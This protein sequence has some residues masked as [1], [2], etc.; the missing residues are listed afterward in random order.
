MESAHLRILCCNIRVDNAGDRQQ[1]DGWSDRKTYCQEVIEA[2]EADIICLQENTNA[3]YADLRQ[4]LV[5][6]EGFGIQNPALEMSP[7]NAILYLKNRFEMASAGGF[8]L[9][10][11]PHVAGSVSWDSA[12]PRFV[13]WV[14]LKDRESG[15]QFR[16]WNLHLDHIGPVSREK[17]AQVFV[18]GAQVY[19]DDFPQLVAG[20]FNCDASNTAIDVI[21]AAGWVDTYTAIHGPEDPGFTYHAFVGPK[22]A[23]IRPP[24]NNIGKID[25]IFARGPV[26]VLSSEIILDSRNGRYPSD[27]YF[28]SAEVTL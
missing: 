19:G 6:F 23:E 9:S 22:F 7:N 2:Q 16:M 24:E 11:T 13:N 20:D 25:F 18:E 27:H 21:K 15:R 4:G 17:Q 3:Q 12:R 14:D 8:W 28:L 1:G 5:E 10:G 26:Q